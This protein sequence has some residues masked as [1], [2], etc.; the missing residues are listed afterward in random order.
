MFKATLLANYGDGPHL[1]NQFCGG[2]LVSNQYIITAA[3]CTYGAAPGDF[4]VGVGKCCN[5]DSLK[6]YV[7]GPVTD[8]L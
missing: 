1:Y 7:K 5:E 3:H 2:T 6:I 4:F 8:L